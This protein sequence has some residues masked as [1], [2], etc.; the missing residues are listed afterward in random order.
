MTT[1]YIGK[2]SVVIAY[3]AL[4]V[5]AKSVVSFESNLVETYIVTALPNHYETD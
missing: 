1:K 4:D 3:D 5:N 2:G